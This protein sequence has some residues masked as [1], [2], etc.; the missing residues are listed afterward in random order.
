VRLILLPGLDGTGHLFSPLLSILPSHF[1]ATVVS[2]PPDQR[3]SYPE[4]CEHVTAS[5]PRDEPYT[6]VAESFSGPIAI[7]LAVAS[8]P[9][10]QAVVLCASFVYFPASHVARLFLTCLSRVLFLVPPPAL[11]VRYFLAGGDAPDELVTSFYQVA[12]TVS[13]SVLSYRLRIALAVDEREAL[14]TTSVPLLFLLPTRDHLLGRGSIGLVSQ[15]RPD[16]AIE[17]I[18]APHLL[19]QRNPRDA[20]QAIDRWMDEIVESS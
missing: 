19:L 7:R 5:L 15:L 18:D 16:A 8:P 13:R 9:N 20:I 6:L 12:A 3:R 1:Q 2:Y 17:T 10:L 11:A 4:L 14:R